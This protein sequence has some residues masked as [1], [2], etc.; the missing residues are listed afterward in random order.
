MKNF[1]MLP[2]SL[3]IAGMLFSS[4]SAAA[5]PPGGFV[6][7]KNVDSSIVQD[8]RYA[9]YHN[10]IGRPIKG[11]HAATCILTKAAAMALHNVQTELKQSGLSLKVYDC[12]RPQQ[13]VNDFIQWSGQRD[14]HA[15][16][17]EFYPR[18]NKADVFKL[19]YV[20][21][22]S[23]HS[24]GSTID[25]T[26]VPLAAATPTLVNKLHRKKLIAC[27]QPYL[28]RVYDSSIDMGTGY[29]CL[30][31]SAH[32]DNTDINLVAY[33]H[34]QLLKA[35]MQKYGFMPYKQEWWHFTLS[36]EPYPNTYFNFPV[37]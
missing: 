8:M 31:P 1:L 10:F 5:T 36:N 3:A 30:D 37:K 33:H 15:M 9:S 17:E 23:G 19:G 20:A 14:Q 12:Y 11:Y 28:K 22:K 27:F 18:V 26:I 4:M 21:A 32:N 34:R 25:L 16:K 6:Y 7:L 29:D 24:R 35:I 2:S 13:A